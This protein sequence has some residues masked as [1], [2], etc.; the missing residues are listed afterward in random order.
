MAGRVVLI[1]GCSSGI[2]LETALAFARHGDVTVASMRDLAKAGA[3]RSRAEAEGLEVDLVPLDVTDPASL[4]AAFATVQDRHGPIDVLVNNA[5]VSHDGPV[6][7]MPLDRARG[8]FETNLWG[9]VNA[10]RAVLPSMRARGSGTV[11]NV[12]S[13]AGRIP[14]GAF[15]SFYD[16]SK[17]A[18]NAVTQGLVEE[19]APYGVRVVSIEPGF[20][21]TEIMANSEKLPRESGPYA[22][23]HEW[24]A[25]FYRRN[26][27]AAEGQ[28]EVVAAAIVA[29]ADDPESPVHVVVGKGAAGIVQA[30]AGVDFE[31]WSAMG[32]EAVEGVA[33]PS[34]V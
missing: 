30:A 26:I 18:L 19:V 12:S 8:V 7:S 5:G 10:I 28:A 11:I 27:A 24:I 32:R 21:R 33:G 25:E 2:G 1:T 22:A 3:L 13:I 16:A 34:P 29:A 31:T 9:P 20:V 6:E 17:H 15:T 4:A 23:H 14:S